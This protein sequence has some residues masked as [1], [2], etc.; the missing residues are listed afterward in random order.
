V[1]DGEVFDRV[2]IATNVLDEAALNALHGIAGTAPDSPAR[3]AAADQLNAAVGEALRELWGDDPA[4]PERLVQAAS[5]M[6]V[7]R[8][9]WFAY[10]F[11]TLYARGAND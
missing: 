11:E 8:L 3:T 9:S 10:A 4:V 5:R 7:A 6:A 2:R 1:N